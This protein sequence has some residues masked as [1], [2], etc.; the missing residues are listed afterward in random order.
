MSHI[1]QR[2][3]KKLVILAAPMKQVAGLPSQRFEI[4][5]VCLEWQSEIYQESGTSSPLSY[6]QL[7][8]LRQQSISG[9]RMGCR[10]QGRDSQ[11]LVHA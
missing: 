4:L 3:A 5:L 1:E 10:Y 6:N 11:Y 2:R 8:L 7:C 9:T